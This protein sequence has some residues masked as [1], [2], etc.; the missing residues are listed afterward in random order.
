VAAIARHPFLGTGLDTFRYASSR[1]ATIKG[2]ITAFAH[3]AYFQV[4]VEAGLLG[5]LTLCVLAFFILKKVY[6]SARRLESDF[7][8][9]LRDTAFVWAFTT[10]FVDNLWSFTVLK[11][12]ISLFFWVV[13]GYVFSFYAEPPK[14]N[15]SG[16]R[17]QRAGNWLALLAIVA[18]L[19][20]AVRGIA[21]EWACG[22]AFLAEARGQMPEAQQAFALS[23]K[24]DPYEG[25]VAF[26]SG[27]RY[28]TVYQQT[29]DRRFL[30]IAEQELLDSAENSPFYGS[31]A[32]L[33]LIYRSE[34]RMSEARDW[35][36][37]SVSVAPFETT[38][39]LRAMG[40]IR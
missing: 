1:L 8:V 23:R 19:G 7:A 21:A 12:N 32:M 22:N 2:G 34:G 3:N 28:F 5:V 17:W 26:E 35:L 15:P 31:R 29:G 36:K 16:R 6:G 37:D 20:L 4:W 18:V 10:F 39:D 24:I 30:S 38:R 40:L 25:R 14:E 13:L 27:K 9:R 11:P 33:G